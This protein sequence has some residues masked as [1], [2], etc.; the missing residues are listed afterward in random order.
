MDELY[1]H[2]P[3][4]VARGSGSRFWDVDGH[5]YLDMYMPT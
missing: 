4:W 2:P 3:L 5:E 1:D